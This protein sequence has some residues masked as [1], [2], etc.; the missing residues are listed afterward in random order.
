MNRN[1]REQRKGDKML[2]EVFLD[3]KTQRYFFRLRDVEGN[4]FANSRAYDTK[5]EAMS[6]AKLIVLADKSLQAITM[7]VQA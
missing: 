7:Q 2:I 5:K 6:I 3:Q 4:I 1:R